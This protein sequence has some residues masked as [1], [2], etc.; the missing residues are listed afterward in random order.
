MSNTVDV[1]ARVEC[2]LRYAPYTIKPQGGASDSSQ[3]KDS[4]ANADSLEKYMSGNIVES[5]QGSLF[6]E[7]YPKML[8]SVVINVQSSS[9]YMGLDL[10]AAIVSAS[11]ALADASIEM[12]DLVSASTLFLS[13]DG[14]GTFHDH[15][16]REDYSA[17][18][19]PPFGM[20][21]VATMHNRSEIANVIFEGRASGTKM[22]EMIQKCCEKNASLRARM[23]DA[24]KST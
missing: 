19:E 11:L 5:I 8:I 12:R 24:I 20:M 17:S 14:K 16:D 23:E 4:H 3:Q 15:I 9:G 2:E 1:K 10:S 18:R 13:Q 6:L 7:K 22:S 21:S